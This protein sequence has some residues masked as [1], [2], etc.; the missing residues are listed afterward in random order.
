MT[1]FPYSIKPCDKSSW[2]FGPWQDELDSAS[3]IDSLTGL[4]CAMVRHN[5]LGH[6][7]GYVK[8][9][10]NS[11]L[12]GKHYY[13]IDANCH[14]G[15]TYG[16]ES[17]YGFDCAHA[18]DLNPR[19]ILILGHKLFRDDIYRD[20]SYVRAECTALARRIMELSQ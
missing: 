18:G 19:L 9:P 20:A 5:E 4:R 14:G 16:Y 10:D 8:L 12:K 1:D 15:L 2:G 11:S 6:W 13:D 3:W 7:C 17:W